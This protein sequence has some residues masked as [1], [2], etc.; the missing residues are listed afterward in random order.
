M[1][2]PPPN[3][4]KFYL[5]SQKKVYISASLRFQ[6]ALIQRFLASHQGF[7]RETPNDTFVLPK[8]H[9]MHHFMAILSYGHLGARNCLSPSWSLANVELREVGA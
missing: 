5:Q 8:G 3:V 7:T 4:S 9:G 1:L 2:P 6:E